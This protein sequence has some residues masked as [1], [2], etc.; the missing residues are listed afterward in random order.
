MNLCEYYII[1]YAT[2]AEYAS[3]DF[4]AIVNLYNH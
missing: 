4:S 3:V 2:L 1:A